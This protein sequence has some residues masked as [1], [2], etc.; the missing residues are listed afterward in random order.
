MCF[1]FDEEH[2]QHILLCAC[3]LCIDSSFECAL[4][5]EDT[6]SWNKKNSDESNAHTKLLRSERMNYGNAQWLSLK[7]YSFTYVTVFVNNFSSFFANASHRAPVLPFATRLPFDLNSFQFN[8]L[9]AACERFQRLRWTLNGVS[10]SIRIKYL[11][12]FVGFRSGRVS[13]I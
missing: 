6:F 12:L 8:I 3:G 5:I 11:V 7:L 2:A 1:S 10:H 9:C 13:G 4:M